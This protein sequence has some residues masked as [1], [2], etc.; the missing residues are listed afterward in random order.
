MSRAVVTWCTKCREFQAGTGPCPV[1][2]HSRR[3][4][5]PVTR[6]TTDWKAN[7]RGDG[8]EVPHSLNLAR[9]R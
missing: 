8:H 5:E 7:W 2:G 9:N 6:L 4:Y 3:G 1:C